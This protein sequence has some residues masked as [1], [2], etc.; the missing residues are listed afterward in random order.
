MNS[1]APKLLSVIVK[2]VNIISYANNG[3]IDEVAGRTI[4]SGQRKKIT[5]PGFISNLVQVRFEILFLLLL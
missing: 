2:S 1:E 3:I 5:A 4:S